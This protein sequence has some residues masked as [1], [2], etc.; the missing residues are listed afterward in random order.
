MQL[1]IYGEIQDTHQR[2]VRDANEYRIIGDI[3]EFDCYDN[4]NNINGTF[5]IDLEDL[6]LVKQY[7]WKITYKRNLPYIITTNKKHKMYVH[8]LIF[9][10]S[11]N[12]EIDHIDGNPLNNC[13]SNLREACRLEQCQNMKAKKNNKF[14][15]RGIS[16]NAKNNLYTVDFSVCKRRYYVKPFKSLEEAVFCRYVLENQLYEERRRN[17][18]LIHD[19]ISKMDENKKQDIL[20]YLY[21]KFNFQAEREYVQSQIALQKSA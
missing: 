9:G 19:I 13:K 20:D 12:L 21:N 11:T 4:R 17:N 10:K 15:I 7:K 2:S 1:K 5:M 3:V 8:Q 16:Y 6:D 18:P 14:G